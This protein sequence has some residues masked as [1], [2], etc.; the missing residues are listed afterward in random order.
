MSIFDRWDLYFH[1]TSST[2]N[3]IGRANDLPERDRAPERHTREK[4]NYKGTAQRATSDCNTPNT[5]FLVSTYF[6]L[7]PYQ[8]QRRDVDNKHAERL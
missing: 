3:D 5:Q 4:R 2:N 8:S 7:D 1:S 6:H